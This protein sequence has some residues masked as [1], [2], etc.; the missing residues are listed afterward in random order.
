MSVH[1]KGPACPV[2]QC[3]GSF[4]DHLRMSEECVETLK[5]EPLLEMKATGEVF[6][7]KTTLMQNGCP[8]AQCPEAGC[9]VARDEDIFAIFFLLLNPILKLD[10]GKL[11]YFT[12]IFANFMH[13]FHRL[14]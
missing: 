10:I 13:F 6:I 9:T 2:C 5:M 14:R 8:A 4:A 7:V 3:E 1:H 12:W 11:I